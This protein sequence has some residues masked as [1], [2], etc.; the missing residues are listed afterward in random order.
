LKFNE[1]TA[2]T[3]IAIDNKLPGIIA[4]ADTLKENAK[5]AKDV[6]LC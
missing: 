3:L 5:E 1:K 2:T 6:F 4:L